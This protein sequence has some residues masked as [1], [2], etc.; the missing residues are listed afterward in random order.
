MVKHIIV[1]I[2]ID[3]YRAYSKDI[4]SVEKLNKNKIPKGNT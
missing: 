1:I 2:E 3:A 4:K